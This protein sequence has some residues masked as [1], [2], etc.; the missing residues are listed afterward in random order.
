[1]FSPA[2]P[3][4]AEATRRAVRAWGLEIFCTEPRHYSALAY[5]CDDAGWPWCR[6]AA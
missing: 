3:G 6:Q 4:I 2:T 5:R 1:M